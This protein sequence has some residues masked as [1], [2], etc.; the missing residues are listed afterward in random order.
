MTDFLADD[1]M[2][3][4][5][6]AGLAVAAIA[7]PLGSFVVW[8]RM[9]YFGATL[10]HSALLGIALGLLVGA[11]PMLGVIVVCLVV[12]LILGFGHRRRTAILSEDTLLGILAHGTLAMGLV[13]AAFLDS[14]RLDLTSYLFGDILAITTSDLVWLYGVAVTVA[15]IL[16]LIWRPLLAATVHEELALV[17]GVPVQA[18]KLGYMLMLAAVVALA[19]KVV[20]ILLVT[21]LLIIPAAAARPLARTPEQMAV[22]ASI[23]GGLSVFGGLAA[24]YI[25]D[26]PSGPSIVV[27]ALVLF[28]CSQ[29]VLAIRKPR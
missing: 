21:S 20:G 9:A 10:S 11:E 13:A 19:M 7:G 15:V 5:L 16:G 2:V 28:I 12:A 17:E 18:L 27:A 26:T 29:S 23:C 4:A 25:A 24:S 3:R 14:V 8:R 6:L 22:L 1:F